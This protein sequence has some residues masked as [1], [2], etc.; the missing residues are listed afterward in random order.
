MRTNEE[1]GT[2]GT[3][4][5]TP[6]RLETA[7]EEGLMKTSRAFLLF[8]AFCLA[9]TAF[10]WI[11]E[12]PV[13]NR[14]HLARYR[15]EAYAPY[16][17]MGSEPRSA[18]QAT[19]QPLLIRGTGKSSVDRGALERYLPTGDANERDRAI[20]SRLEALMEVPQP[21]A[22]V[23]AELGGLYLDR[24]IQHDEPLDLLNAA[25]E[26]LRALD[27]EPDHLAASFNLAHVWQRL[28]LREKARNAWQRYLDLDLKSA[29]R[30]EAQRQLGSL[31]SAEA[32]MT[33]EAFAAAMWSALAEDERAEVEQLVEDDLHHTLLFAE[34]TL[35]GLFVAQAASSPAAAQATLAQGQLLADVLLT[36]SGD[37]FYTDLYANLAGAE[38]QAATQGLKHYLAARSARN[39]DRSND[40]SNELEQALD[41]LVDA[42]SP[43]E[44]KALMLRHELVA[45]TAPAA[46]LKD[47]MEG[48]ADRAASN[49]YHE[50]AGEANW[51]LGVDEIQQGQPATGEALVLVARDHFAEGQIPDRVAGTANLLA[52][53]RDLLGDTTEAWAWRQ[54]ALAALAD[55]DPQTRWHINYT[56]AGASLMAESP[57]VAEAFQEA[58][59]AAAQEVGKCAMVAD[60][61]V[62]M[63]LI[64]LELAN[65]SAANDEKDAASAALEVCEA[66]KESDL[67]RAR[68]AA[69]EAA[70][71]SD[72]DPQAAVEALSAAHDAYEGSFKFPIGATLLQRAR[73][74]QKLGDQEA[75]ATDLAQSLAA[76]E[77]IRS[78]LG[79][80]WRLRLLYQQQAQEAFDHLTRLELDRGNF[81]AAFEVAERRRARTLLE[82]AFGRIAGES[83]ETL[84]GPPQPWSAAEIRSSLPAGTTLVAYLAGEHSWS[85]WTLSDDVFSWT[86]LPGAGDLSA[87]VGGFGDAVMRASQEADIVGHG[88]ELWQDLLAPLK[89]PAGER[90]VIIP[91]GVLAS[92]PFAALVDPATE[93]FLGDDHTLSLDASATLWALAARTTG[94]RSPSRQLGLLAIGNPAF[95]KGELKHLVELPTASEEAQ[96]VAKFYASHR[97]LREADA[98]EGAFRKQVQTAD[99]V[100]FGGHAEVDQRLPGAS[101]LVFAKD[102]DGTS[103]GTS[104]GLLTVE[105]ILDLNLPSTRLVVLAACDSASGPEVAAEGVVSLAYAFKAAGVEGVV[106]SLAN[107]DDRA[108]AKLLE[109][110]H[111]Q[112]AQGADAAEALRWAQRDLRKD[113]DFSSPKNWAFF[114]VFGTAAP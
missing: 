97:L 21:E 108:T 37:R 13:E 67:A 70:L 22:N 30:L 17:A 96:R 15:G 12:A 20:E 76:F 58:A 84:A 34:Q 95:D 98:T 32:P 3:L 27:R 38:A 88:K 65:P 78:E 92:L 91:D 93:R 85:A 18:T 113:P 7:T 107:V 26:T 57:Q 89:I 33:Q 71:V 94:D 101:R 105:E 109:G 43:L 24:A 51:I 60:G 102:P 99:V 44:L 4:L 53:S 25:Q 83:A 73:V 23:L 29:W 2:T 39:E 90:L 69:L 11:S 46:S 64:Q 59:L 81:A 47:A 72:E 6:I 31:E 110:F 5:Y 112:F 56:A 36:R 55:A 79:D 48:V 62:Q 100:H 68:L 75:A 42:E 40:A 14:T 74:H 87:R 9:L 104:D 28:G 82:N 19:S 1:P 66:N 35:P 77:G 8:G 86:E 52:E 50:V 63:G 16:R 45:G 49:H 41:S 111:H 10:F 54:Q 114:Q 106:A 80:D 103:D 61:H